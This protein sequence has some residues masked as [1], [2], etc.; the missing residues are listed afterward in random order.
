MQGGARLSQG[1]LPGRGGEVTSATAGGENEAGHQERE[2]TADTP[3]SSLWGSP[4]I[5]IAAALSCGRPSGWCAAPYLAFLFQRQRQ[6]VR[7]V[8]VV[9]AVTQFDGRLVVGA[10][11]GQVDPGNAAQVPLQR[12][13]GH[14]PPPAPA[15]AP[16]QLEL[17]WEGA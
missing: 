4:G 6:L 5:G 16:P 8:A 10:D 1:D 15:R 9:L 17:G 2:A 12:L 13:E 7:A 14:A 11:A 3:A